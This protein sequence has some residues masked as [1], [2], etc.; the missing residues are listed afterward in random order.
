MRPASDMTP[1]GTERGGLITIT[2]NDGPRLLETIESVRQQSAASRITHIIVDS[3]T[4]P[5]GPLPGDRHIIITPPRGVY[6]ALNEG[7]RECREDIIGMVHGNDALASPDIIA[8]VLRIFGSDPDLDFVYGKVVYRRPGA[9]KFCR[10][11][12]GALFRPE[13]L[14]CGFVPPHPSLFVRRRVFEKVGLYDESFKVCGDTEMWL[15]LFD[16]GN[17]FRY[18]YIPLVTTIMSTGGISSKF[19]NRLL[20]HLPE[21]RRALRMHDRPASYFRLLKRFL[22]L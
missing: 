20:V 6:A 8:E 12:D 21:K 9:R 4:E 22:Y 17:A 3:S 11:Y 13:L 2:R 7:I 5:Q 1:R 18:R 14:E 15:R 10:I 19:W 16:P